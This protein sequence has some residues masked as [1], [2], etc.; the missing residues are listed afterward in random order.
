VKFAFIATHRGIWPAGWLC[1]ALGVSRAGFYAWRTRPPSVRAR[2]DEQLLLRVRASFLTSDRTYGARRVWHDMLVEGIVC[3]LHRIE[4]LMR[5]AALRARPRRRRIPSDT[6]V[7]STN[8]V[9]PNVLN[10]TFDA[11]SANRKWVADF[12]YLWTAEGWLYVAAV[13]DLFSRRV[14]GWSMSATM[15]A[16]LVTD[17]LVMAI[18]RRGTPN[19]VLHH[20]DRGSQYTSEPF[21]RLLADH[22]VTC[23]MSRA[24]NVWDNAVMESFFSS[25]KT[26]RTAAKT[27]RT[28]DQA[29][30][31]V[32]DYIERFYNPKR[33]HSTLGYLSPMEFEMQAEL[34]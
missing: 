18:W 11:A 17:A 1:E 27:Y 22:G 15:T 10:R 30:A 24:G 20:S 3:G 4:R 6:G 13:V 26:E 5:H 8:A 34:A 16:Q 23:S 9:A 12:T 14:V 7:C 29:K 25:L 32:F 2:V 21:Q 33:R 31:D 28:R 19:T